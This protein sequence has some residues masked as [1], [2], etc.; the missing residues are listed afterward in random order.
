MVVEI[1]HTAFPIIEQN[2]AFPALPLGWDNVGVDKV[3][4]PPGQAAEALCREGNHRLRS[5]K[6]FFWLQG[7][8]KGLRGN[9]LHHPGEALQR[10]LGGGIV[11]A[12]I[13]QIQAEDSTASLG[14]T[15]LA[16][17]EAGVVPVGGKAGW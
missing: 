15:W 14:G 5:L 6:A 8:G 9:A 2:R 1:E 4:H 17:Q 10:S 3:M 7:K 11:V 12:G 16:E 13:N